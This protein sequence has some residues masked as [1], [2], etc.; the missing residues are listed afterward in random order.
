MASKKSE[1]RDES[2]ASR[3]TKF[4]LQQV[5]DAVLDSESD[6]DIQNEFGDSSLDEESDSGSES[7]SAVDDIPD[8]PLI[9]DDE[10]KA[11]DQTSIT[12]DVSNYYSSDMFDIPLSPLHKGVRGEWNS[13]EYLNGEGVKKFEKILQKKGGCLKREGG[14]NKKVWAALYFPLP[15]INCH[16]CQHSTR[17]LPE[18]FIYVMIN[19]KLAKK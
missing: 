8:V 16:F 18:G 13:L 15:I 3:P 5:L 1:P 19:D 9:D 12:M 4:S 10:E 17:K 2:N 7:E 14:C 11:T 6:V